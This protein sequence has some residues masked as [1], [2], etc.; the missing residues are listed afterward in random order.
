[1]H[2]ATGEEAKMADYIQIV[3]NVVL[4]DL[5]SEIGPVPVLP[6]IRQLL[7]SFQRR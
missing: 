4:L 6:L 5:I 3:C 2:T 1:M 7:V